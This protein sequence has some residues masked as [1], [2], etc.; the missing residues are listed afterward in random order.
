MDG[1]RNQKGGKGFGKETRGKGNGWETKH[2]NPEV[3][4]TGGKKKRRN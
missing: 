4:E 3:T 2:K 1:K